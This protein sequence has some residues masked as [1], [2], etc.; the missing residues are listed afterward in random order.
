[1]RRK[2]IPEE[3]TNLSLWPGV[4]PSALDDASRQQYSLRADAIRALFP[5][6][7]AL[8]SIERRLGVQRGTIYWFIDRCIAPHSDGRI[9]GYRG[10]IPFSRVK[11][12]MR[13][14]PPKAHLRN[15]AD[16]LAR[17]AS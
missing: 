8:K 14:K 15:T 16:W 2:D 3:I 12:Y 6:A 9:Q 7:S 13:T 4:D 10:L 5:V 17:L 11:G 1:M